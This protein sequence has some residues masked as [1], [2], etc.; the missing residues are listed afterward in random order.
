MIV[1]NFQPDAVVYFII[2]VSITLHTITK[3]FRYLNGGTE[4]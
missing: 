3:N 4:P 2:S 1:T